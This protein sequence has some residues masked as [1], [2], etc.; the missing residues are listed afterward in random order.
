MQRSC[1]SVSSPVTARTGPAGG[2]RLQSLLGRD[3]KVTEHRGEL[4]DSSL[5]PLVMAPVHP[6]SILRARDSATRH[7]E[8]DA[9][10]LDLRVVAG[11]MRQ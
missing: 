8:L 2:D 6:S 10:V 1:W 5:A 11:A 3:L 7:A 9:F 4:A